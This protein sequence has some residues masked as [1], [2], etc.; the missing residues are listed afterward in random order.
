LDVFDEEPLPPT[1]RFWTHPN[2][3]VLPHISAPTD[4]QTA[5]EVVADT[6]RRFRRGERIA[7]VV[8]ANRGY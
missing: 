2:V 1:S 6:V 5:A 8:D 7:D 3:T 4:R